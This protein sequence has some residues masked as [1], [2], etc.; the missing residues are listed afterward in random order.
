MCY[1]L[2]ISYTVMSQQREDAGPGQLTQAELRQAEDLKTSVL[3]QFH[4][5]DSSQ[6]SCGRLFDAAIREGGNDIKAL[7]TAKAAEQVDKVVDSMYQKFSQLNP[8]GGE[9]MEDARG[10]IKSAIYK[11]KGLRSSAS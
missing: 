10:S 11:A 5:W 2:Q 9:L 7:V 4:K 8:V 1:N 3:R 6:T